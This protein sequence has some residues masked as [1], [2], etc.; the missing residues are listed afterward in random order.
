VARQH[1]L[2]SL[3]FTSLA[4]ALPLQ[5]EE[6]AVGRLYTPRVS[7]TIDTVTALEPSAGYERIIN[8]AAAL[9]GVDASLIRSVIAVE[10]R[11]DPAAV[12]QGG[13][14]GLMQ[15]MPGVA[16]ALGVQHPFDPREN[17]MAGTRLLRTLLDLHHGDLSMALASYNAGPAAVADWGGIPPF[18][19]T[20]GYVKRVTELVASARRT[21][22]D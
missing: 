17:I 13:A 20:E 21:A 8:E 10:S 18:R 2:L 9:H 1:R 15:L 7:T 11:F 6:A 22:N 14:L 5:V 4:F 16:D 12:S 19:E 3:V